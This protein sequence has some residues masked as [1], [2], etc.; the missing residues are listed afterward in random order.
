MADIVVKNRKPIVDDY[1][2]KEFGSD[3]KDIIWSY[4]KALM[5]P[6]RDPGP[7]NQN[8]QNI[9]DRLL[10]PTSIHQLPPPVDYFH[11]DFAGPAPHGPTPLMKYPVR[12]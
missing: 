8:T 6:N 3:I 9:F 4:V 5:K 7:E 12:E 10:G 1:D 2:R 11:S